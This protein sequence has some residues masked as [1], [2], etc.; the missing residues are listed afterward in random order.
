MKRKSDGS[1]RVA[2]YYKAKAGS[3][4]GLAVMRYVNLAYM[5]TIKRQL[6]KIVLKALNLEH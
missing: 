6:K 5:E 3:L 2:T 4:A 1:G